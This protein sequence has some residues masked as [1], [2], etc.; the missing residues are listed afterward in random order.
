MSRQRPYESFEKAYIKFLL[1]DGRS[2]DGLL[3]LVSEIRTCILEK[4]N[5][6]MPSEYFIQ[7]SN[8]KGFWSSLTRLFGEQEA[9]IEKCYI[10]I[11]YLEQSL[12][13]INSILED[14]RSDN[15]YE[16]Y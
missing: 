11:Q 7:Y 13:W 4:C 14:I 3:I 12:D 9:N 10:P 8:L 15:A 6:Y 16:D 5:M 1:F 2:R